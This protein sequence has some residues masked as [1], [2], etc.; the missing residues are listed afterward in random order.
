M[1]DFFKDFCVS[2]CNNA[3]EFLGSFLKGNTATF[4]V[5]APNASSVS[6]VGDFNGWDTTVTLCKM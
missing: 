1:K 4:R 2:S 6:V 3:Y 5:W